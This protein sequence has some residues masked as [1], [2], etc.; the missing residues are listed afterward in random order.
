MTE[1]NLK[2][3]LPATKIDSGTIL[4]TDFPGNLYDQGPPRKAS[5][6]MTEAHQ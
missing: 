3:K 6:K 4:G 1:I 5:G 2:T